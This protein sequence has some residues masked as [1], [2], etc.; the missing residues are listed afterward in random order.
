MKGYIIE[1]YSNM[2]DSYTVS[3]LMEEALKFGIDLRVIGVND[4]I[5]K[6]EKVFHK[7]FSLD[8]A[9]FV[10]NRFK[11]GIIKDYINRLAQKSYND[12]KAFKKYINKFN[13][14]DLKGDFKFPK[15]L[16]SSPLNSFDEIKKELGLPFVAKGLKSSQG[17][18]IFL[19]NS[20]RDYLNLINQGQYRELLFQ[21]YIETNRMDLRFFSIKGEV[22]NGIRRISQGDFRC[23][24]ALGAK[25]EPIIPDENVKKIAR[26]LYK[27]TG[28]YFIG[29]DLF[30]GSPY[31]LCEINVM[32]GISGMEK[33]NNINIARAI[34]KNIVEDI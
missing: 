24:Y 6:D 30:E 13:Q 19:I 33:A 11:W 31:Y 32:P 27:Q 7:G 18:E 15:S 12:L 4:C 9:D 8:R 23:N 21:E 25:V 5:I 3:R 16:L 20:E 28:L 26:D 29:I 2:G 10:I 34:L 22:T 1:K 17:A 14:L